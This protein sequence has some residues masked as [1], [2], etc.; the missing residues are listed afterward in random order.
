[1]YLFVVFILIQQS[2]FY[3]IRNYEKEF[4]SLKYVTVGYI[5]NFFYKTLNLLWNQLLFYFT[6]VIYCYIL[7]QKFLYQVI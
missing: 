2:N 6:L 4:L 5:L 7:L 3:P 1:M